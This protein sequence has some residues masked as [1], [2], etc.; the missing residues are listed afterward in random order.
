MSDQKQSRDQ[1]TRDLVVF[2]TGVRNRR[3]WTQRAL[4]EILQVGQSTVSEFETAQAEPRLTTLARYARA[5]GYDL[6]LRLT[7]GGVRI[8]GTRASSYWEDDD[9]SA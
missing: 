1:M 6:E 7:S 3:G 9:E 4:A 8:F 2:L 5:L